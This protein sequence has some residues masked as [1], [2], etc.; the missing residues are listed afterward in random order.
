MARS[1]RESRV[2]CKQSKSSRERRRERQAL[3]AI[4]SPPLLHWANFWRSYAADGDER[5]DHRLFPVL[6][7]LM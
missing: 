6:A 3:C 5:L 4:S 1:V 2:G 7:S